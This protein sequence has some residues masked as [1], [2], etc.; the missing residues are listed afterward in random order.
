[1]KSLEGHIMIVLRKPLFK[2][3]INILALFCSLLIRKLGAEYNTLH[4]IFLSFRF[5]REIKVGDIGRPKTVILT[6]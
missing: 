1:M 3:Q 6:H 4:R 2:R 5:L